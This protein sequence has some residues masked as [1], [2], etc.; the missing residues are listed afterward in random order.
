MKHCILFCSLVQSGRFEILGGGWVMPDEASTH[1]AATLDQL[2][3][4]HQW[5]HEYLG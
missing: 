2:I 5:I 1:Y 3:E 4:G